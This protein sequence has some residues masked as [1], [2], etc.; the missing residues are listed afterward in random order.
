MQ[1]IDVAYV[2]TAGL[3]M[4]AMLNTGPACGFPAADVLP[5]SPNV[6]L[7]AAT[8]RFTPLNISLSAETNQ[9]DD[10]I[11]RLIRAHTGA[12][13]GV[14]TWW[15]RYTERILPFPHAARQFTLAGNRA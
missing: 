15:T 2:E 7:S 14:S 11:D 8:I 3:I 6:S 13:R 12:G 9:R 1:L 10:A 5:M 4:F